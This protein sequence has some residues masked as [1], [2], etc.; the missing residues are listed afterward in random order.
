MAALKV[1]VV[2]MGVLILVGLGAII[3]VLATGA[4]LAPGGFGARRLALPAGARVV[5]MAAA[6]ERVVLRLEAPDGVARLLV[7]DP[8]RGRELGRIELAP[9]P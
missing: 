4:G 9:A 2:A 1:L 5:E 6:G 7:V 8:V 3:Y